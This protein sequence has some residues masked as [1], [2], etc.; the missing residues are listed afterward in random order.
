[1]VD[2]FVLVQ[3]Y[4][5]GVAHDYQLLDKLE[6]LE[7][8]HGGQKMCLLLNQHLNQTLFP[9]CHDQQHHQYNRYNQFAIYA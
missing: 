3:K 5:K 2:I 1:M 8:L 4:L 9:K 7:I 6:Y